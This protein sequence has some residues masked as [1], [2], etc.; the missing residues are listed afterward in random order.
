MMWDGCDKRRFPRL[1]LRCEVQVVADEKSPIL[2]TQTENLGIG[3]ICVILDKQFERFSKC[4]LKI[5]F[6]EKKSVIECAGK[7]VWMVKTKDVKS[8]RVRYDTGIEF[9]DIKDDDREKIQAVLD[10]LPNS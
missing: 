3:G 4:R 10:A 5:E 6:D 1:N 7:V 9:T 2:K 8:R